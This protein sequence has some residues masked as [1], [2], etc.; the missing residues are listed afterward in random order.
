M[1]CAWN[2]TKKCQLHSRIQFGDD[3]LSSFCLRK[4]PL[5]LNRLS[6]QRKPWTKW[7]ITFLA[8]MFR[9]DRND[10]CSTHAAMHI[11]FWI[12]FIT[13]HRSEFAWFVDESDRHRMRREF[14]DNWTLPSDILYPLFRE[15]DV[16]FERA[17]FFAY[18]FI[19]IENVVDDLI[20]AKLS[21]TCATYSANKWAV[22][23]MMCVYLCAWGIVFT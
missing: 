15:L 23:H 4:R 19:Q 9:R 6:L 8:A 13:R 7:R 11:T 17:L 1:E 18:L 14:A 16:F 5:Q 20:G 22:V 2:T 10:W 21:T 3:I 12:H